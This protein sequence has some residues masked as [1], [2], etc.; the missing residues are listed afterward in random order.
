MHLR[1][2]VGR[3]LFVNSVFGKDLHQYP[4]IYNKNKHK[5]TNFKSSYLTHTLCTQNV[6]T[7][8]TKLTEKEKVWREGRGVVQREG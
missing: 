2:P 5:Y 4:H 7:M 6:H 8:H 3:N 1:H